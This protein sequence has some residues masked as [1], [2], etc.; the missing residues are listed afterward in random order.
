MSR[1]NGKKPASAASK[2]PETKRAYNPYL[3]S[4]GATITYQG[5]QYPCGTQH[6]NGLLICSQC[7][8]NAR[9]VGLE[10]SKQ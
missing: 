9:G 1:V 4:C 2:R 6:S 8:T 7:A 10:V 3:V 5:Q